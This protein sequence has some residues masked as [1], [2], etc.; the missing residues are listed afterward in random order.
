MNTNDL[1]TWRHNLTDDQVKYL[2]KVDRLIAQSER[3]KVID[4]S[5]MI[6]NEQLFVECI[7]YI[8]AGTGLD[9][10]YHDFELIIN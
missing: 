6:K 4:M 7:Q 10:Y 3:G 1:L 5:N 8:K 2:A 9:I